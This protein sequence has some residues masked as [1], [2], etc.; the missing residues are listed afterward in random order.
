MEA[1]LIYQLIFNDVLFVQVP[2]AQY[3]PEY[4]GGTDVNKSAKYILWRYMQL[5]RARIDL[6]PQ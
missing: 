5:N 6:Y 1:Q 3:C 4:T 2:L